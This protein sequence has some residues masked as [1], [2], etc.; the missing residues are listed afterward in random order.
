MKKIVNRLAFFGNPQGL[1]MIEVLMAMAI[2]AIGFLAVSTMVVWTTRNNTTSNILTQATMLARERMEFLK[3]LPVSQMQ[4]QCRD[5]IEPERLQTIFERECDVDSS[6]SSSANI[7]TVTVSWT[8]R[9]ED[10]NVVLR[11]LTRGNGT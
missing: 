2:F 8:R 4:D 3:T 9:G 6:F 10:R 1:T 5:D 7:I 11:T